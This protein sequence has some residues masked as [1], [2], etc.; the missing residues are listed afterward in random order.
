M[1]NTIERTFALKAGSRHKVVATQST[2]Y[3]LVILRRDKLVS[4]HDVNL[5]TA[6][7]NISLQSRRLK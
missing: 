1:V 4:V 2:L 7:I 3:K 6:N 5:A